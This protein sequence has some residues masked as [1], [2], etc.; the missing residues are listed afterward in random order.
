[1]LAASYTHNGPTLTGP[2]S[3]PIYYGLSA[4]QAQP[5]HAYTKKLQEKVDEVIGR[6][7]AAMRPVRLSFGRGSG[8]FAVNR[9]PGFRPNPKG[10]SD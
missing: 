10:P 9:R 5:I 2:I 4:A 8:T 7:L 6:A 3:L 1:M